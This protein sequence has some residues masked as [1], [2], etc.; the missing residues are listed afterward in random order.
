MPNLTGIDRLEFETRP[1]CV[2]IAD[3]NSASL[4][5]GLLYYPGEGERLY[6]FT[7]AHV[8]DKAQKLELSFLIPDNPEYDEYKI[9]QLTAPATQ[10]WYSPLDRITAGSHSHDIAVIELKKDEGLHLERT[11]YFVAEASCGMP[12]YAQ[13]YPGG[14]VRE[15]EHLLRALD[16]TEGHVRASVLSEAVFEFRVEDRFLDQGGRTYELEGASGSPVWN[17]GDGEH[18]VT[19]LLVRGK[20]D[21]VFRGRVES[22][23]MRFI[24]SMMKVLFGISMET[25][26][27]DIPEE[28]VAD[29]TEL[30]FDAAIRPDEAVDTP[31]DVWIGEQ[32]VQMKLLIDDLKM[33]RAINIGVEAIGDARYSDCTRENR[34]KIMKLL[35][36]CYDICLLEAE[37]NALE[38][39]MRSEGLIQEHDTYRWMR[40]LFSMQRY[41]ELLQFVETVSENDT[42]Y[43]MALFFKA[44][45]GAFVNGMP[46]EKTVGLYVDDRERLRETAK[47]ADTGAFYLQVV[48]YVY[49]M[50][51]HMPEKAIRCLNSAYRMN[52]QSIVLETL[53]GAYYQL[54]IKDAVNDKNRII[55]SKIDRKNLYKAR[56]CFLILMEKED[57]L[58]FKGA[59]KRM[60]WQIFHTFVFLHDN[61]RIIKLYPLVRDHF[62][63]QKTADRRQVERYY[64]EVIALSGQIDLTQFSALNKEDKLQLQ[65]FAAINRF[66]QIGR[67]HPQSEAARELRRTILLVEKIADQLPGKAA[68][69]I[70]RGVIILCSQGILRFGW[71]LLPRMRHYYRRV[72]LSKDP[73]LIAEMADIIFEYEHSYEENAAHFAEAF[74]NAP[75]IRTWNA[76]VGI[77]IRAGKLDTAD[78]MY[79]D[80]L[81][82]HEELYRDEPE[83][84]YRAY[85]DFIK[86]HRRDPQNALAYFLAGRDK[87][88]D[89]EIAGFW[90]LELMLATCTFNEPERFE[91]ERYPFMEAGL[92][93][94]DIYYHNALIAYTT[95]LNG[96]KASEM[97][98]HLP[99]GRRLPLSREE[100]FYLAWRRELKLPVNPGWDGFVPSR[101]EDALRQYQ[102][103]AWGDAQTR[104][105]SI[106]QFHIDRTCSL[107]AWALYLLAERD[108]LAA[109]EDADQVYLSHYTID[110]LLFEISQNPN[111]AIHR[112]LD[113]IAS[114][115][116]IC[117]RSA[118]FTHQLKVR[119]RVR[120]IEPASAV[121]VALEKNCIAV[122][123]EPDIDDTLMDIFSSNI[124][125]PA[126]LFDFK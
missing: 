14:W 34:L 13:G 97:F 53:A 74:Q 88:D 86:E 112:A 82:N 18:S 83:Y 47:D 92:L 100:A 60:G 113:F 11:E 76:L 101:V 84:A 99:E 27:L 23:K 87:F 37:A 118:D 15:T 65:A 115:D 45:A 16:R 12:I 19:G 77:H 105:K 21:N 125:R 44:M 6:V 70:Y 24:Q 75:S 103:E 68:M 55:F 22:A 50:C 1:Y 72:R 3:E 116:N 31:Q 26:I 42:A 71:N 93:P 90:E 66:F 80:L 20:R 79:Q 5:S 104:E 73:Q 28:E 107:D 38:T 106:Q 78:A 89:K 108:Q 30:R 124:L 4:G 123:G 51:Y 52:A 7:C 119:R 63:F 95:N 126:G 110:R 121:A 33:Q 58:C 117:I 120:Y 109:L 94:E 46:P 98:Q 32:Q 67:T 43:D 56:S 102:S 36:Y 10:I 59:I 111:D 35:I 49:D 57:E 29:R 64:A 40:Y 39:R 69:P 9:C 2:H 96:P 54:A 85:L 81:N 122:I 114:H 91:E 48:G 8:V 17:A 25:K 62:P 61:Y 41:K